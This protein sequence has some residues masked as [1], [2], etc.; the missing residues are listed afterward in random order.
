[1]STRCTYRGVR[2]RSLLELSFVFHLEEEM[3]LELGRDLFYEVLKIPYR[4]GNGK[5]RTYIVDFWCPSHSI[6]WE[7]KPS[8]RV[9]RRKNVAKAQA[10]VVYAGGSGMGYHIVTERDFIVLSAREA[11]ELEGVTV[12]Q[13][14]RRR[15]AK[16]RPKADR[17]HR[18]GS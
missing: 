7:V 2:L 5:L 12:E 6:A 8:S 15:R 10:A 14:V 13:K 3:G 11:S 9:G 4:V 17:R 1:V 18:G 16:R